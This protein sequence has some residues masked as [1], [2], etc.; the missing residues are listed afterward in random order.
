MS[1]RIDRQQ[2]I[3]N[4]DISSQES[5]YISDI[6]SESRNCKD[7]QSDYKK[8]CDKTTIITNID[9]FFD[10]GFFY[11]YHNEINNI[12]EYIKIKDMMT[13]LLN[14][15]NILKIHKK[16]NINGALEIENSLN[17][18]IKNRII[19]KY[20]CIKKENR[21]KGHDVEILKQIYHSKRLKELKSLLLNINKKYIELME[22]HIEEKKIRNEKRRKEDE[23]RRKEDEERRKE[24][25]ERRKEDEEDE[26]KDNI[27][28]FIRKLENEIEE[29]LTSEESSE[30]WQTV[31]KKKKNS[32]RKH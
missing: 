26:K 25:E 29:K 9:D 6:S 12:V 13:Q 19:Y 14:F 27:D 8:E 4:S 23:E 3:N 2:F 24:H 15:K 21:N 22:I 20:K 32:R 10:N 30:I 17:S 28:L 16:V 31:I 11:K 18:C 7:I 5:E 1:F